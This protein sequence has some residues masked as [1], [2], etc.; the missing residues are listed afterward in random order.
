MLHY[1]S[2]DACFSLSFLDVNYAGYNP[3]YHGPL[4]FYITAGFFWLFGESDFTARLLAALS[5]ILLL[6][7]IY[8]YK[9]GVFMV[10]LRV[11]LIPPC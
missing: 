11:L 8:Y 5:G 3:I 7:L 2:L 1:E 4:R 6:V 9:A 10:D